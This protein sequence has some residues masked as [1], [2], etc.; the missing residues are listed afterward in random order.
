MT[1]VADVLRAQY[2]RRQLLTR[3][4]V[5]A[6]RR[7]WT[8][9]DPKAVRA[10]WHAATGPAVQKILTGAQWEAANVAQANIAALL[11]A[12]QLTAD[13][14]GDV[15]PDA[16][17]GIAS[18]GRPTASL[19]ELSNVYALQRVGAGENPEDAL[20]V[21][22][23]WLERTVGTQV[24]DAGRGAASVA[25]AARPDVGGYIRVLTP[26][27]C[28]R[29]AVL[30]GNWYRWS[31]DFA[32][33]PSCDC[34]QAPAGDARAGSDLRTDAGEL[35][36][37]GQITDL[38]AADTQAI[39]DG[40]D[41]SQVVNAG[42]GMYSAGGRSFTREGTSRRGVYGRTDA[43]RAHVP[44]PTPEQIYRDAASRADAIQLLRRFGYLT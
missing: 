14:A 2:V 27:S 35:F 23:R 12:Q 16:F 39:R 36:R 37:A 30:A 34:T 7:A 24:L 38:S 11:H 17:A 20:G 9:I 22:G 15:D 29:C 40:A 18:D 44:R 31:A 4:A 32:R 33:H 26:P 10:S 8:T 21:A 25:I 43:G 19:L 41:I 28:S 6:T 3:R 1:A 13:P 42:R 5:L